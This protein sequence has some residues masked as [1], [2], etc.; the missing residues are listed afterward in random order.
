[1]L[2][3]AQARFA[4]WTMEV[5]ENGREHTTARDDEYLRWVV[6]I[7][8]LGPSAQDSDAIG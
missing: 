8:Q 7:I 3:S 5:M 1:M 4:V 2:R 6:N